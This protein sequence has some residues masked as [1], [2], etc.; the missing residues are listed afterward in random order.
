MATESAA[1]GRRLSRPALGLRGRVLGWY[2][3]LLT[4][5]LLVTSFLTFTSGAIALRE[6]AEEELREEVFDFAAYLEARPAGQTLQQAAYAYLQSWPAEDREAVLIDFAGERPRSAGPVGLEPALLDGLRGPSPRLATLETSAGEAR[7]LF[8]PILLDGSRIGSLAAVHLVD[9]GRA[10][11]LERRIAIAAGALLA[12]LL[13]STLAWGTLGRLLRPIKQMARTAREI[14]ESGD[15]ARRIPETGARDEVG[16]L[17][18][19]FN[20]ML[21]RLEAA[22]RRERWFIRESSHELRTPITICRGHLE[23][24]GPAPGPK[25]V[26]EAI[27]VVLEELDRMG[28][29]LEDMTTLARVEDSGFLCWETVPAEELLIDA[30]SKVEPLLNGR[31]QLEVPPG[32]PTLRADRYRLAQALVNLLHNA[33]VHGS[34]GG[35]VSLRLE[36]ERSS[37]RFEVADDGGGLPCGEEEVVFQ[38]FR[39]A[40]ARTTGAGLG[41]AIARGIAQAHGGSAGVDNRPGEG[42]TFW[43]RVPR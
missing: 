9:E 42:A 33:A 40:S 16:T 39:R 32:Q 11:L 35:R 27:G 2:A 1:L 29:I 34:G 14:S 10:A 24:L 23:I 6:Q 43:L 30:A 3:L 28:R 15:L 31:L 13:A 36:Q 26:R 17:A 21:G 5:A 7:V 41:L 18:A 20:R 8:S 22:F 4:L 38:P 19:A 12:F 37:W 25:E